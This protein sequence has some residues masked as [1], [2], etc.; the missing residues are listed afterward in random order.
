MNS[1]E[2]ASICH[3]ERS[4]G[5]QNTDCQIL[6]CV[7]NDKKEFRM[8]STEEAS[9]CHPERGVSRVMDL[10]V[11]KTPTGRFFDHASLRPK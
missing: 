4:E 9:I 3:P 5:S 7:Q 2:E 1:T 10:T 6:H 8:N 11:R